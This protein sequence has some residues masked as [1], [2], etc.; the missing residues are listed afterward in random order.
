MGALVFLCAANG[1]GYAEDRS[2]PSA[3]TPGA[4]GTTVWVGSWAASQQLVEPRNS[5]PQEDLRDATLRQ[6]V[7]LSIGG[8]ELRVHVSNRYGTAPLRI[9]SLHVAR[10]LCHPNA[11]TPGAPLSQLANPGQAGSPEPGTPGSA[12]ASTGK[13]APPQHANT[14]RAG[15]PRACATSARIDAATDKAVTFS[16]RAD[17][18]IPAGADF[19]SDPVALPVGELSDLTITLHLDQPPAEQTGHPGSRATSY[20]VHGD[21]VSVDDL[22]DAKKVEHWYFIAGVDVTSPAQAVSIVTLGDSITDGHGATTDGNDRWPD[23]LAR[24]LQADAAKRSV[25]VLNHGIGGNRLLTDGLGPNALARFDHD[26]L[27]QA[28]VRYL[29][30]LEGVNDMGMA[31][32]TAEITK[33]EHEALVHRLLA[34][35]E[36][37]IT[38]AHAHGIQVFGATILPFVGSGFYHPG[39]ESEADRQA[40]N[41]WIRTAGR[42]D[43][44]IDFDKLM[45]DP[46]HPE[47]LLPAYDSGD[48]LHPSPAGYAAM[49]TAVPLSLFGSAPSLSAS[50]A[51]DL[52]MAITFDDLPAHSA[53]PP[54]ATRAGVAAKILSALRG[55]HVPGVYGFVNGQRLEQQ[56]EDASVLEAWRKAGYPLGNHS[57]SHMNLDQNT[58]EAFASDV[59]RNEA[60]LHKWMPH[61]DWHWF[62]FPFLRE[63]ETPEKHAAVRR[64]LAQHG[65][66]IAGVTMSFGD[67]QWNEPYA[68]CKAKGDAAAI[69]QLEASYLAAAEESIR[70]DR[71]LSQ[72]LYGRDIPYVL[73]MHIGAFDAEMLPRLL[74]LYESRGFKFVTL[75]EAESDEFYRQ[76]TD[77]LLPLGPDSLTG[78]MA[79]RG[80]ALP[81]H[82]IAAPQ[83][84]TVCR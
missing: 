13:S 29:I 69:T 56:P 32:R 65:Y 45:R 16:G 52:R 7:H 39:P 37:I 15:D 64:F 83:L 55:A 73:L 42:F 8:A 57:W 66:K 5:L 1:A 40:V 34:A 48:H 79:E 3:P 53:L 54:G 12:A 68:R 41:Q 18:T 22:P 80:L 47:R 49:G 67:Y 33:E 28:G 11:P 76:A 21:R 71:G 61:G 62:R 27:A 77:P 58:T 82:E 36:Q 4:P 51:T 44:V 31:A 78:A 17:A 35:Y 9:T 25:A 70:F 43:A 72:A 23:V 2:H 59:Q 19:V 50:A 75:K 20:V 30:V 6:V 46:E 10:L 14:A 63:G 81:P 84:E 26:V 24:R 60:V 38:R 74:K